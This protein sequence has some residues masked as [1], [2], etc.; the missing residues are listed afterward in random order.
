M[1]DSAGAL[2]ASLPTLPAR[3]R[4]GNDSTEV[5][6]PSTSP[7]GLLPSL[8]R[9]PEKLAASTVR[10]E[11]LNLGMHPH[12][13]LSRL[14][15]TQ[16]AELTVIFI[17]EKRRELVRQEAAR[18][19]DFEQRRLAQAPPGHGRRELNKQRNEANYEDNLKAF[20]KHL[21]SVVQR[22]DDKDRLAAAAR[23]TREAK[24]QAVV[25]I[26]KREAAKREVEIQRLKENGPS[27]SDADE[28]KVTA[29][30]YR[31]RPSVRQRSW[32]A[33]M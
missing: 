27:N 13:E 5:T 7:S 30:S 19:R 20:E 4:P 12:D 23:A 22:I 18:M 10:E 21:E 3:S 1:T 24:R 9:H 11:L 15:R 8:A 29:Y 31:P 6:R 26:R 25:E 16:Q 17:A 2:A 32:Y 28:K 14:T 33:C